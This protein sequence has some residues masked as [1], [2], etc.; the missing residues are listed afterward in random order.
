MTGVQ[1]TLD[2]F[3][4]KHDDRRIDLVELNIDHEDG[5]T[6]VLSGRILE[7]RQLN[8]LAIALKNQYPMITIETSHL[9]ILRKTPARFLTVAVNL[10]SVHKEPSWLAEMLSQVY[11]GNS[12][13]VL[14]EQGDWVFTRQEDGYLGWVY[15]PYLADEKLP[16]P[17]HLVCAPMTFVHEQPGLET[18]VTTRLFAGT[19]V[20]IDKVQDEWAHLAG[21]ETQIPCRM[22]G[23][24]LPLSSLTALETIP[25]D[26]DLKRGIIVQTAFTL[27]GTPYL[28]GGCSSGGIDCSGLARLTH[29]LA[30][31][32]IP[33]D[34]DMQKTAGKPVE[35]PLKPGDLVFF[36]GEND[37]SHIT[38]V[39]ISMGG[40]QIIHSSRMNNGVYT[41]WMQEV[42]HLRDDFAGAVTYLSN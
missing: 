26:P 32:S 42:P 6:L 14:D 24:W 18:P 5:E 37:H 11:Y 34:A 16:D 7:A 19:A 36:Y 41:N 38:H 20:N 4:R 40:D 29:R 28:W 15:L 39:G 22:R 30:G 8:E 1:Q 2:E 3:K 23:G 33:R 12:L 10:T 27:Y 9:T 31:I 35:K 17:T 21:I 25:Q 13:E